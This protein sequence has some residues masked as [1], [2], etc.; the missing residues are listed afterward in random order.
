M[1]TKKRTF[2]KSITW[3]IIGIVL[4]A[5]LFHI[6]S[7]QAVEVLLQF[8]IVDTIIKLLSYYLHERVW[9]KIKWGNKDEEL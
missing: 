1:D 2:A 7:N 5:T 6:F 4:T 9:C 3:R 8:S